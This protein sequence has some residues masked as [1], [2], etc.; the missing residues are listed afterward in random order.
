[1]FSPNYR[2]AEQ[3]PQKMEAYRVAQ[4]V[5]NVMNSFWRTPLMPLLLL[6]VILSEIVSIY[7]L[8][9]SANNLT[10]PIAIFFLVVWIDFSVD[11][12]VLIKCLSLSRLC[13][14]RFVRNMKSRT[15]TAWGKRFVKSCPYLRI[16]MGGNFFDRLTSPMIWQFCVDRVINFLLV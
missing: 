10:L 15:R 1:M 14:E 16:S 6:L 8:S 12:H 4:V 2:Q 9:T 3:S 13:S 7:I 11:V 5:Q